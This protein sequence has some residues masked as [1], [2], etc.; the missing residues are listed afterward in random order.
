MTNEKL[1][2]HY[3]HQFKTGCLGFQVDIWRYSKKIF[4]ESWRE[5]SSFLQLTKSQ[6]GQSRWVELLPSAFWCF[7]HGL[8]S[9][10]PV[11]LVDL[12]FLYRAS[13]QPIW[14][15]RMDFMMISCVKCQPVKGFFMFFRC[16]TA[17]VICFCESNKDVLTASRFSVAELWTGK[18]IPIGWIHQKNGLFTYPWISGNGIFTYI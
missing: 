9:V 5:N 6:S 15:S 1:M 10:T 8:D 4:Q 17:H 14:G 13:N 18:N 11:D 12:S 2:V 3:L 7:F 16:Q